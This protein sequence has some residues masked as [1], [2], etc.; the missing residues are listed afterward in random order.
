[1]MGYQRKDKMIAD[2]ALVA[3]P[4]AA[5]YPGDE[6]VEIEYTDDE[7]EVTASTELYFDE[8]TE[9][10]V[11]DGQE[12]RDEIRDTKTACADT[13]VEANDN[14]AILGGAAAAITLLAPEIAIPAEIIVGVLGTSSAAQWWM[15]NRAQ[16]CANDPVREDIGRVTRY[17]S[18]PV[19]AL[20]PAPSVAAAVYGVAVNSLHGMRS[21]EAVT[22]TLE[23]YGGALERVR[24]G[25]DDATRLLRLQCAALVIN[26]HLASSHLRVLAVALSNVTRRAPM[27]WST[28]KAAEV[29]EKATMA[30]LAAA[31]QNIWRGDRNRLNG[32]RDMLD[33][34]LTP[35]SRKGMDAS[36]REVIQKLRSSDITP[37]MV[38]RVSQLRLN[39]QP[40]VHAS[41]TFRSLADTISTAGQ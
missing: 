3:D 21:L 19:R 6:N 32:G 7:L 2:D 8:D 10:E 14:A 40:F 39:V 11:Y 26:C 36:M 23:R 25:H 15:G 31:L 27:V 9:A 17:R 1:M 38:E 41:E 16:K 12:I 29:I 28:E 24:A 30:Q 4:V 33:S 37:D 13:A 5:D 35:A 34:K 18:V 22:S 20:S